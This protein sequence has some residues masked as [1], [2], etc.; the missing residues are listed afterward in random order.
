MACPRCGSDERDQFSSQ[1]ETYYCYGCGEC[2]FVA[3]DVVQLCERPQVKGGF[4][5]P[6]RMGEELSRVVLQKC[7]SH[8]VG[9]EKP[10]PERPPTWPPDDYDSIGS[11]EFVRYRSPP[12]WIFNGL[13]ATLMAASVIGLGCAI[14][15]AIFPK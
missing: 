11:R 4:L 10:E 15:A 14:W 1:G 6:D 7:E 13:M 9:E 2:Y 5:V 8:W 3:G 12:D